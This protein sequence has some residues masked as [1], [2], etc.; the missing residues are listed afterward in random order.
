MITQIVA[1]GS[2]GLWASVMSHDTKGF[3]V[4]LRSQG[5]LLH[6]EGQEVLDLFNL[7]KMVVRND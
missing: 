6:I 3:I 4:E 2:S 5:H 7:L 1:N